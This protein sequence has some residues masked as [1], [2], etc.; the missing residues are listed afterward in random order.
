MHRHHCAQTAMLDQRPAHDRLHFNRAKHC[1]TGIPVEF[2]GD[3]TQ[4]ERMSTTQGVGGLRTKQIEAIVTRGTRTS[5]CV[6]FP[7]RK[8]V[9]IRF[10]LGISAPGYSQVLSKHAG[11]YAHDFLG[12]S[13][14]SRGFTKIVEK[15]QAS[16]TLFKQFLC[17][18][19]G[20][21]IVKNQDYAQHL[22]F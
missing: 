7:D 15:R 1:S 4:H 17:F 18:A 19:P 9:A 3:I 20:S 13:E 8:S 11:G 14:Q 5:V 6:V 12:I 21:D 16:L 2:S 10:N 22:A